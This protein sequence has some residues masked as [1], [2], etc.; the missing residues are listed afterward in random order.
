MAM[1]VKLTV[2][3]ARVAK[4]VLK[5]FSSLAVHWSFESQK[6]KQVNSHPGSLD[7]LF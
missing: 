6:S 7:N 1:I 3:S 4:M 5:L 2:E